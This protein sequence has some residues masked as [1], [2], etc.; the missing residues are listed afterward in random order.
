MAATLDFL[1]GTRTVTGSRFLV[2]TPTGRVLVDCGLFQGLRELRRRNWEPFPVDPASVD[3]V[4]LSH[5]HLDHCGYLPALV[6]DGF[7]GPVLASAGTAKLAAIVLHDSAHLLEED[8]E[9][10][11]RHGYFDE[12]CAVA[13]AIRSASRPIALAS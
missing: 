5:A 10:A 9:H 8:T 1:G 13:R 6:R 7:S 4:V 11:E 2:S 12:M 3:A